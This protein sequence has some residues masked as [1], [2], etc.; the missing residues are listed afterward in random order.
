MKKIGIIGAGL[1]GSLLAIYLAK[2][3][4]D[5]TVFEVR[6]DLRLLED[7]GGRSIN[8]AMSCRG[9]TALK[10]VGLFNEV[11]SIL[12]PMRGRAIHEDNGK[13]IYA[14]F[15]R[16][17]DECIYAVKRNELNALLLNEIDKHVN[18]TV[19]FDAKVVDIAL[20][21]KQLSYT[22]NE[23]LTTIQYDLLI[24]ADGVGSI[25]RDVFVRD[26]VA[27][28]NRVYFS[29]GY[30][31]LTISNSSHHTHLLKDHL[32]LWP[33]GAYSLLGN[34]NLDG[35][36]TGSLFLPHEGVESFSTLDS[37]QH[38]QAFFERSFPDIISLLPSIVDD[39][40]KHPIGKLSTVESSTWFFED[41]ALLLGDAAHGLV[42]FFGQGMNCS[43]ED[44]RMLNA[45]L[46][47]HDDDFSL[48]LPLFYQLRAPNASAVSKMSMDNYTEIQENIRDEDFIQRKRFE[49]ML[50]NRYR[51]SY[52][53][54][55][56][57]V[58][59]TNTPYAVAYQIGEYQTIW[60]NELFNDIPN[61]DS[62]DWATIDGHIKKYVKK[63]T[64]LNLNI[65]E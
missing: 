41:S 21:N 39:Y 25:L 52:V 64:D 12:T 42:P 22:L 15:G 10:D 47:K 46:D 14:S 5:I 31:E 30:K 3:Q 59:F 19:L 53:S 37:K 32:H 26:G 61:L 54:K 55:H 23:K 17:P 27:K 8:L 51:D 16:D 35:S 36:I 1:A 9:L 29:E 20:K 56:V 18:I 43:F 58:M 62:I 4:Y 45:L 48:V 11:Q 13:I 44:C 24:G 38:V 49:M 6:S 34:P 7:E 60:L 33:R 57:L 28:A 63:L 50:M 2:R 65:N 40:F